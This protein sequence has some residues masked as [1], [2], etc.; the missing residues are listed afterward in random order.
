MRIGQADSAGLEAEAVGLKPDPRGSG[1]GSAFR[2]TPLRGLGANRVGLK[3]DPQGS[4][5]GARCA[6]TE[7]TA[8]SVPC[9]LIPDS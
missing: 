1:G 9:P 2:P 5:I 3:P 7:I 6:A 8:A 4:P